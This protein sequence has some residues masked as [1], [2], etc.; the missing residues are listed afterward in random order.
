MR[1]FSR[2]TL[3]DVA[4]LSGVSEISVSR[5]MRNAPNISAKLR[6]KVEL[7]AAELNY[8]PNR[9]A[10]ALASVTT[11]LVGVILPSMS[12]IVFPVVL[13]GIDSVLS[14]TQYRTVLGISHYDSA[15]EEEIIR[16][17]LAW[18]PAGIIVA[19]FEHSDESKRLLKSSVAPVI[20]I[21][22]ADGD[23]IDNS[24]GVSHEAAGRLMAEHFHDVGY[25][26][27]GYIGAWGERPVRSQ[28]RRIAFEQRL[29]ELN[30][31]LMAK[32]IETEDSSLLLG[33]NACAAILNEHPEIEA[34]FFANDDLACGA[35]LHCIE[36]G[37]RVP[38]QIALA[39]FNGLPL[40]DAMPMKLT[41]IKTPR[42]QMGVAAANMFLNRVDNEAAAEKVVMPLMLVEGETTRSAKP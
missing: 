9:V 26:K 39:G 32:R 40:L 25:K 7:A 17:I 41:T 16:D 33:K 3:K 2:P 20:E 10:G 36:K 6:K 27:I 8:T 42:H 18:N 1:S 11:D 23:P 34:L 19:G 22:D 4:Q 37:I 14:G 38:E 21:M 12:N 31:P 15:R 13:D 30:I 24:L 28:K 29:N 5:V 35:L